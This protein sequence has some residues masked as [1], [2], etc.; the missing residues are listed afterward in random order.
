MSAS[1]TIWRRT[2]V[3]NEA[4][5]STKVSLLYLQSRI[6]SVRA[7]RRALLV[8][9]LISFFI[10]TKS[11]MIHMSGCHTTAVEMIVV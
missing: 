9:Q 3:I 1:S 8:N 5:L 7:L 2:M 6:F 4:R 11:A 10:T